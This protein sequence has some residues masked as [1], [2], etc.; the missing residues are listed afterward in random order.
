MEH[1]TIHQQDS[2]LRMQNPEAMDQVLLWGL[3]IRHFR[4]EPESGRSG[5]DRKEPLLWLRIPLLLLGVVGALGLLAHYNSRFAE[6][7]RIVYWPGWG[8]CVGLLAVAGC[9]FLVLL[10]DWA[11]GRIVHA[12]RLRRREGQT[13]PIH[14]RSR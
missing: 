8:I 10:V 4:R 7:T 12:V 1:K 3:P 2:V 14:W 6:A 9:V 5:V 13:R 11:A